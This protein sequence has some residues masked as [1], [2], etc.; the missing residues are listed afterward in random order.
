MSACP[1]AEEERTHHRRPKQRIGTRPASARH[2]HRRPRSVSF[3]AFPFNVAPGSPRHNGHRI[4]ATVAV[5][6]GLPDRTG[7]KPLRRPAIFDDR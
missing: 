4:I 7:G 2:C 5:D 3:P 1:R 6:D